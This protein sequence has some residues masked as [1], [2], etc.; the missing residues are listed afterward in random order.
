MPETLSCH[1][2]FST[3][4]ITGIDVTVDYRSTGKFVMTY[5]VSGG[6]DQLALPEPGR[7]ARADNLWEKTCFEAFIG[8][9]GDPGYLE[10]NFS[11]SKQWAVY[12]FENYREG[13]SDAELLVPPRIETSTV[14]GDFALVATLDLSGLPEMNAGRLEM[15]LTAV[16]L[17]KNGRKSFWALSHP[18]GNPDFHNRDCFL[19]KIETAESR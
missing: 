2:D 10:L 11:P 16:I 15:A 3:D 18:S 17:E 14:N 12:A 5:H 1:P 9:Q 6:V 4:A 8:V 13:M 7:P 19:H